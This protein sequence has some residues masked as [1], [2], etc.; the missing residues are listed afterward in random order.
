MIAALIAVSA[1]ARLEHL[2]QQQQL[3]Q[4]LPP[5]QNSGFGSN[6]GLDSSQRPF[7]AIAGAYGTPGPDYSGFNAHATFPG[8]SDRYLPP[9]HGPSGVSSGRIPQFS[10]SVNG[11]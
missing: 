4:Y 1:A 10:G 11:T 6:N 9:D 2:E 7:G 8:A 3:R 5:H